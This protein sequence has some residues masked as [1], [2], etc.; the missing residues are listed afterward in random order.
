MFLIAATLVVTAVKAN[1]DT[2]KSDPVWPFQS[3]QKMDEAINKYAGDP[4]ATYHVIMRAWEIHK[5]AEA[6][7]VYRSLL[8]R[9]RDDPYLES[10]YSFCQTMAYS[11]VSYDFSVAVSTPTD[12]KARS[13]QMEAGY[14]GDKAF[15]A[16]P[17]DLYILFE[18]G[19]CLEVGFGNN[20]VA[21]RSCLK[22]AV[23]LAPKWAATHFWYANALTRIPEPQGNTTEDDEQ[24]LHEYKAAASLDPKLTAQALL[25][26]A[27]AYGLLK[28]YKP[29]VKCLDQATA[30][31]PSQ[32]KRIGIMR[33]RKEYAEYARE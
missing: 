10:A 8:M 22:K 21:A 24:A 2:P 11:T 19:I 18:R 7:L 14:Y 31:D 29:A 23:G 26:E 28:Q 15:A 25:G 27:C 9:K 4:L 32:A 16:K 17:D 1:A 13:L 5:A 30:L 20:L 6:T 12:M 33:L 3:E